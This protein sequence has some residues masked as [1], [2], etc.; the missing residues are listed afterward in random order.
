MGYLD[1]LFPHPNIYGIICL[2]FPNMNIETEMF[3]NIAHGHTA[4][5]KAELESTPRFFCI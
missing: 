1:S 2:R 5:N 3:Q 4:S